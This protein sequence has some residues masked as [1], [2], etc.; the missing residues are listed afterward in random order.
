V[1]EASIDG[2]AA[3]G[4]VAGTGDGR[5]HPGTSLSRDQSATLVA[6]LLDALVEA[7]VAEGP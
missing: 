4:I 2:L 3:L 1:H 6:R 5:Y 7:G